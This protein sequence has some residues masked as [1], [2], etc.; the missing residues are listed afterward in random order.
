MID[1]MSLPVSGGLLAAGAVW[2]GLSGFVLGPVYTERSAEKIDWCE[3]CETQLVAEIKARRPLPSAEPRL[4]CDDVL[5]VLPKEYGKLMTLFGV[6]AACQLVDQQNAH[7]QRV[8]DLKRE[9]VM[10]ATEHTASQCACAIAHLIED[11][12]WSIALHA[13]TARLI[14]PSITRDLKSSL[15]AAAKS[16]ECAR[17]TNQGDQ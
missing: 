6:D 7:R 16:P 13:G 12:R 11:K 8:A 2:V 15:M 5:T 3:Q 4:G 1:M 10:Q 14:S 17:L 9:R